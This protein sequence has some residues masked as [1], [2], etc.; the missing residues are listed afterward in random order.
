MIFY[1]MFFALKHFTYGSFDK[2]VTERTGQF[3]SQYEPV[4]QSIQAVVFVASILKNWWFF[5][6]SLTFTVQLHSLRNVQST[7]PQNSLYKVK[8]KKLF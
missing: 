3:I 4:F 6:Y 8:K 7:S 5:L 2:T 1:Y